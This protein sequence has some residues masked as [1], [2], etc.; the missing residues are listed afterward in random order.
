MTVYGWDGRIV[1]HNNC[2]YCRLRQVIK[3]KPEIEYCGVNGLEIP[4]P[5][6]GERHC[7]HY[8]QDG[9]ASAR[10]C[11]IEDYNCTFDFTR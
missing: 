9:C 4:A 3:G 2:T 8:Q 7:E 11:N 6:H 10:G 1:H 5:R